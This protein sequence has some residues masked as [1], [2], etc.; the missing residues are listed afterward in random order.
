MYDPLH[1][2]S[3]DDDKSRDH[4]EGKRY[5]CDYCGI[6]LEDHESYMRGGKVY[7]GCCK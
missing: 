2:P 3:W 6:T 7:C 1:T 5:N 4:Y